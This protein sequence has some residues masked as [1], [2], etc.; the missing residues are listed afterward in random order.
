MHIPVHISLRAP[1]VAAGEPRG[2]MAARRPQRSRIT[3]ES[4]F[5]WDPWVGFSLRETY[6]DPPDGQSE[7]NP[8]PPGFG[9]PGALSLD[10]TGA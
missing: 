2:T 8:G 9:D 6:P 10:H 4:L 7:S 5:V 3:L 1:A